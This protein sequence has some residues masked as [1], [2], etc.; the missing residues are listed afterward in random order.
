[1]VCSKARSLNEDNVGEICPTESIS[2]RAIASL[3][4]F[5]WAKL[6]K[7]TKKRRTTR[8]AGKA[9]FPLESPRM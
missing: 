5:A 9:T 6:V 4:Y 7:S 1:M 3:V 8:A 2:R